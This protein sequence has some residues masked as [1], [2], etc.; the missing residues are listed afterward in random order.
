MKP[1][2][3]PHKFKPFFLIP[4]LNLFI[5]FNCYAIENS[6]I[7]INLSSDAI[8]QGDVAVITITP[9]VD[10]KSASCILKKNKIDFFT[11]PDNNT[12]CMFLAIDL[13][14]KT[15]RK[16]LPVRIIKD[17][18][19][20]KTEFVNYRVKK[21]KFK[22]QELTLPESKVTLSKKNL[23]RYKHERSELASVFDHNTSSKLW[24]KTFLRPV[25]GKISTPFGVRRII[26]D[27]PKNPHSG[28]DLKASEGT[29]VISANSGIVV[30]TCNHFFTGNSVYIDHGT[31]IL[32]MYFHLSKISVKQ[33]EKIT[34]GQVIGYV[35]STGRSTGPHL[36]WG[37]RINNQRI[38]PISLLEISKTFNR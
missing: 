7:N 20:E 37:I 34:R 30:L 23:K 5:I 25:N 36:H 11:S 21:K 24:D 28:V 4:V 2:I 15:G 19:T 9:A 29:P 17:D 12:L 33:G 13:T 18:G 3:K 26:N 22:T 1:I 6:G 14:E 32:T 10:I 38:D 31:G 35:G 8:Y 16:K 27:K